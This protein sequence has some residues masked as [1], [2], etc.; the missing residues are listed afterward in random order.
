MKKKKPSFSTIVFGVLIILMIIPQTRMPI[1]EGISKIRVAL[2][3]PTAM[4]EDE[5]TQLEPFTYRL[6]TLEGAPADVGIGKGKVTFLSYWATW[7]PPC[8]AELPSIQKLYDDYGDKVDFVLITHEDPDVIQTFLNK[9][10]FD[11]PVVLPRM[12][13]PA[14]LLERTIPTNYVIDK[15]GK[16]VVKEQGATDWNSQKIRN[17]LDT[18]IGE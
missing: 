1:Q 12:E 4:D 17:T 5:Q 8:R 16:V 18:L 11:F 9:K 6:A 3:S 7:C 13:T 15:T 10:E 2:F 14:E